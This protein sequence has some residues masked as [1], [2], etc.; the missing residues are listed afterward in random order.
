MHLACHSAAGERRD[1]MKSGAYRTPE[2]H[3][4]PARFRVLPETGMNLPGGKKRSIPRWLPQA[5][6][7]SISLICLIYVLHGYPIRSELLP[8]IRQLDWRWMALATAS[9]LAVYV[10]HGWRWTT[11]LGPVARLRFWRTVQSIYIGLFANEV[12]PLRVGELIRCYLLA[13]WNGLRISLAFASAAVERLIDGLLMVIAFLITASFVRGLPKDLVIL[14][15]VVGGL[16]LIGAAVLFWVVTRKQE[17]HA[18]L[19]ESR[20]SATL[21]HIV[22]GLHLMGNRRTLAMTTLVSILYQAIQIFSVYAV[23]K[24]YALDLSFWVAGGVMTIIRF[25]TVVPNAPAN[26]GLMNVAC[27]TALRLFDVETRDA[28]TF[29][30][31]LFAA[32]TVPLILGGALATALTGLN[33]GELH[34]Q[35]RQ[36]VDATGGPPPD[37]S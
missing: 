28:K 25:I 3:T 37:R 1:I 6:G 24:A 14:V 19:S 11:L 13:H 27:I 26:I 9:D 30:I 32:L 5:A 20:W 8:A 21:R 17:A 2:R 10:C 22:E 7:Y 4:G 36:G 23:M 34:K 16:L 35:A 29:S 33:I 18:V 12:L 31:I 15:E